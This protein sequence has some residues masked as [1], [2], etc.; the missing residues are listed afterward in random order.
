MGFSGLER[1]PSKCPG[2][3]PWWGRVKDGSLLQLWLPGVARRIKNRV[4]NS[5]LRSYS[6]IEGRC[7]PKGAHFQEAAS[8]EFS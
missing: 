3:P 4:K 6:R 8:P 7:D 5:A 2:L 1:R